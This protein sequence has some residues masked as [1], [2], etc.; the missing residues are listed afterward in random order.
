MNHLSPRVRKLLAGSLLVTLLFSVWG[1][2]LRPLLTVTGDAI[3]SLHDAQFELD[4]ARA[5][6][7]ERKKLS[8]RAIAMGEQAIRLR[9]Q[10]GNSASGAI[11]NLQGNVS[12]LA[13]SSGLQ[14]ESMQAETFVIKQPLT[15]LSVVLKAKGPEISLL[16]ML[17]ALES[18]PELTVINRLTVIAQNPG[19]MNADRSSAGVVVEMRIDGYW[20]APQMPVKAKS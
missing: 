6:V 3:E 1:L 12:Q 11:G 13:K 20:A 14:L 10:S 9:L 18:Q 2:V 4:R 7:K 5:A 16:R 17:A 15:K 8:E 19:Q